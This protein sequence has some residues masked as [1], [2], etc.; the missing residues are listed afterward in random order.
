MS[1]ADFIASHFF[2]IPVDALGDLKSSELEDILQNDKLCIDNE[3]YLF[4]FM[5]EHVS[6]YFRLIG[7]V[8]LKF[9]SPSSMN[10]FFKI[11]SYS[12]VDER[13]WLNICPRARHKLVYEANEIPLNRLKSIVHLTSVYGGHVHER[14]ALKITC[15]ST[16][17]SNCLQ[18]TCNNY[19]NS[20]N[21]ANSWIQFDF[22]NREVSLTHY[23]LKSDGGG[24]HLLQWT[25][26][27]SRN[28]KTW[29]SIDAGH[30]QDLNGKFITKIFSCSVPSDMILCTLRNVEFFG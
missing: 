25:L 10:R 30:T 29:E 18:I 16:S 4:D 28:G 21:S 7:Y 12:D 19:W 24:D 17:H 20:D 23:T 3:D 14:G 11:I 2:E 9:L 15:S 22:K 1:E 8:Q 13:I 5:V 27:G 26:T 6:D